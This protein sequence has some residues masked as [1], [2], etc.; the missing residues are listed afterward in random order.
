MV[1][2]DKYSQYY[3]IKWLI[4]ILIL[5]IYEKKKKIMMF[6]KQDN[7]LKLFCIT[8]FLF[9]LSVSRYP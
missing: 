8:Q 6:S 7:L 4:L 9:H 1:K 5:F 2:L 3:S